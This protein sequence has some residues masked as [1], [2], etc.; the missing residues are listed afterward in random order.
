M[1]KVVEVYPMQ[2]GWIWIEVTYHLHDSW[3][4]GDLYLTPLHRF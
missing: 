2:I 1:G 3:P 4:S